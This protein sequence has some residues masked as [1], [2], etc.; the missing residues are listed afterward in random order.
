MA[1]VASG[2]RL[3]PQRR[4]PVPDLSEA[5]DER[6]N[7]DCRCDGHSNALDI[8][9]RLPGEVNP[10]PVVPTEVEIPSVVVFLT[11]AVVGVTSPKFQDA[12]S[13]LRGFMLQLFP[14]AARADSN[15]IL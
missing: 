6:S 2:S 9:V 5:E 1:I 12:N 3:P 14:T 4:H 10:E 8:A 7:Y 15:T 13:N 11:L